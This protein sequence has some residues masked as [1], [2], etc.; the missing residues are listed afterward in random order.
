MEQKRVPPQKKRGQIHGKRQEVVGLN[1]N[2]LQLGRRLSR[3]RPPA[4]QVRAS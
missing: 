4:D 2:T 3:L 1:Q